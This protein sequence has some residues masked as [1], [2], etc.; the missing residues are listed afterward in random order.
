MCDFDH[1]TDDVIAPMKDQGIAKS[2]VRI[3]ADVWVGVRATVLRGTHI[4]RGSVLAAHTVARG[5]VPAYSV[6]AGVPGRV[7]RSRVGSAADP[8][9]RVTRARRTAR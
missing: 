4:G 6:V 7:V 9:G 5:A 8:G 2:P 1:R 3:E